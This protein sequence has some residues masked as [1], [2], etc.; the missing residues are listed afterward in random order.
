MEHIDDQPL[1]KLDRVLSEQG[2][3]AGLRILNGRAPH[4]FTGIY[5]FSPGMLL[6]VYLVDA[7]TPE[8]VRGD[9]VQIEDAYCVMLA[10]RRQIS[11]GEPEG[12]P[13]KLQGTSPV[14]SYC[15]VLLVTA[16]GE[17]FGSLCHF[18]TQRCQHPASEMQFLQS[19]AP[20]FMAALERESAPR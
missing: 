6:N 20:A 4:R 12:S 11:F 1:A 3:V 19:A 2:V 15:G 18:D 13:C 10:D 5:K 7:F 14:I 17:P 8:T 9:D 16:D